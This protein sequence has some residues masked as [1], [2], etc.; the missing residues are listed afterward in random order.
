LLTTAAPAVVNDAMS[1]LTEVGSAVK[2]GEGAG[3]GKAVTSF[4]IVF[5]VVDV[6]WVT[7]SV[8]GLQATIKRSEKSSAKENDTLRRFTR[9]FL[10]LYNLSLSIFFRNPGT[11]PSFAWTTFDYSLTYY[12]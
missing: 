3:V 10:M 11:D 7:E 6:A 4:T 2:V 5:S 8:P 12:R 1:W 9:T